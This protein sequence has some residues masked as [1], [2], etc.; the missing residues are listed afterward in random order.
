MQCNAKLLHS[1]KGVAKRA[2]GRQTSDV[3]RFVEI[4]A[5]GWDWVW[6]ELNVIRSD[7]LKETVLSL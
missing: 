7:T 4:P 1:G 2:K 6:F 3:H 5:G